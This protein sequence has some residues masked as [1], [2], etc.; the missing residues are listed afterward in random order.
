MLSPFD[1]AQLDK[2]ACTEFL[3]GNYDFDLLPLIPDMMSLSTAACVLDISLVT[4]EK[5]VS[6]KQLPTVK[7]S[8]DTEKIRKTDLI[9]Y[10]QSA[11]CA[12]NPYL[13]P[14]FH[15]IAHPNSPV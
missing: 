11:F 3:K 2:E 14:K 5:L 4:L 9:K 10:I 1:D 15:Q 13:L 7:P 6:L 8:G 12:M